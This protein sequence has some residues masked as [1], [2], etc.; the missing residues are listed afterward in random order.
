MS[1]PESE[2]LDIPG[3]YYEETALKPDAVRL[4]GRVAMSS[5]RFGAQWMASIYTAE[6]MV[7][8]IIDPEAPLLGTIVTDSADLTP[9][10]ESLIGPRLPREKVLPI[11]ASWFAE[12]GLTALIEDA[13]G[14]RGGIFEYGSMGFVFSVD[15]AE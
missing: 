15:T 12:H 11:V 14:I 3:K 5:E 8:S 7:N 9:D 2:R 6:G 1:T 13:A 4:A 10:R